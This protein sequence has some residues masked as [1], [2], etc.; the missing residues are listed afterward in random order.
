MRGNVTWITSVAYPAQRDWDTRLEFGSSG[1]VDRFWFGESPA[2]IHNFFNSAFNF[3]L[4]N[5]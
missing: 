4:N 5:C 1:M 2:D 3:I